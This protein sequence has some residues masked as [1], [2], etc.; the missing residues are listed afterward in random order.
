MK[1]TFTFRRVQSG[2]WGETELARTIKVQALNEMEAE[3]IV[4]ARKDA[5]KKLRNGD[6]ES[7]TLV[8]TA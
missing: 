2:F 8:K 7:W 4:M 1:T 6:N 5:F 3:M